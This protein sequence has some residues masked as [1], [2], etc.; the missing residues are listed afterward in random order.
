M[1]KRGCLI[2]LNLTIIVVILDQ[3]SKFL[4]V[5]FF[6]LYQVK[7]ILPI[8]NL[9]LLRNKGAAFN[10]LSQLNGWASL[11]FGVIAIAVSVLILFW[12]ARLPKTK[13]RLACGLALILGGALGNLI[14]R[15]VHGYVIDF[16]DFHIQNWHWPAFNVADSAICI[17]A[18]ILFTDVF[19]NHK[20]AIEKEQPN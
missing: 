11:L 17:G 14:D 2:W 16:L 19:F 18:F 9:T 4:I 20:T 5:N 15:I 7:P 13:R 8:F 3:F 12:L 10:L 6:T 1:L